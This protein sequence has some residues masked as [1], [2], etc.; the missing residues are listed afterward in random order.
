MSNDPATVE[1]YRFTANTPL[2]DAWNIQA[3]PNGPLLTEEQGFLRY[4][5]GA[6][7]I[8]NQWTMVSMSKPYRILRMY[9][10]HGVAVAFQL[11]ANRI[12]GDEVKFSI[13]PAGRVILRF[14]EGG[15]NVEYVYSD[16]GFHNLG[17]S[18]IRADGQWHRIILV[19]DPD[20]IYA[21]S[22]SDTPPAVNVFEDE[23]KIF[24]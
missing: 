16:N 12:D 11:R 24:N 13:G 3:N 20:V 18:A 19:I 4:Q 2:G 22:G 5:V 6:L 7:P 8:E 1:L 14:T 21:D 9:G 17:Q 15:K 10:G 23:K